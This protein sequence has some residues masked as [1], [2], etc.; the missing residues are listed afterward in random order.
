MDAWID[1]TT[2]VLVREVN[3]PADLVRELQSAMLTMI[4]KLQ[5]VVLVATT[6]PLS[7]HLRQTCDN[8]TR[9]D[10]LYLVVS[11][12]VSP[13][14]ILA[15]R[16]THEIVPMVG[17]RLQQVTVLTL[18]EQAISAPLQVCQVARTLARQS[19]KSKT[20]KVKASTTRTLPASP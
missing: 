9:M 7:A 14:S 10:E 6:V 15:R 18:T 3:H 2:Y 5:I 17:W 8:F 13:L 11:S 16:T 20:P 12:R 4:L 19:P 1:P